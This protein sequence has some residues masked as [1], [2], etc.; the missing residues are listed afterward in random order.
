MAMNIFWCTC[1]IQKDSNGK[2][3]SLSSPA[4][5]TCADSHVVRESVKRGIYAADLEKDVN[6]LSSE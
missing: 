1:T 2:L 4:R 5:N 3:L 6:L